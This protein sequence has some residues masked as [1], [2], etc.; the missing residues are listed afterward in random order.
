[1]ESSSTHSQWKADYPTEKFLREDYLILLL[2]DPQNSAVKQD[3]H[4]MNWKPQN[5]KLV[6]NLSFQKHS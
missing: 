2:Q 6:L 1:M 4:Y 3:I 5:G